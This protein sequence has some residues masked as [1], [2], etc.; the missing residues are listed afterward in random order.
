[1]TIH[2][3]PLPV[4]MGP[5]PTYRCPT[6]QNQYVWTKRWINGRTREGWELMREDFETRRLRNEAEFQRGARQAI[7]FS[8]VGAV[9]LI[10]LIVW[11]VLRATT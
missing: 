8:I 10:A 1:M 2:R 5:K 7:A 11:I 9:V 4:D 6:C 3:C